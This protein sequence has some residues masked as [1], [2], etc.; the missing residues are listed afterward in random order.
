MIEV[1]IECF[2]LEARQ[3]SCTDRQLFLNAQTSWLI[4]EFFTDMK[5][6]HP[7]S[8]TMNSRAAWLMIKFYWQEH[9]SELMTEVSGKNKTQLKE[10]HL[11]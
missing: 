8:D 2:S 10:N 7:W 1:K 4:S 5:M 3:W 6:G 11:K 9:I